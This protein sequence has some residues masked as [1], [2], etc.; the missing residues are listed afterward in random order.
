MHIKRYGKSSSSLFNIKKSFLEENDL[1]VNK[2]KQFAKAYINQPKRTKCKNC[3][4]L[5]NPASDFTKDS[6]AYVICTHC[7]HLNGTHEDTD[8]FCR[9]IY[10]HDSGKDYAKDY[11]SEDIDSYNFRTASIY[12]PKAEFLYTSLLNNNINPQELKYIDFGAGSGYFV[13]AL[14]KIG[15]NNVYGTEV[16]QAQTDFG[17]LMIGENVLSTHNIENTQKVLSET[18]CQVVS[19]IG[20]LE[21]IQKPRE[22]LNQLKVN[23]NVKYLYISVPTFSLSVYLE[24]LSNEIFHRQLHGGHTHLYTE[25]SLLYLCKEFGFKIIAEWW[26]GTDIMDL[27]RH[28]SVTLKKLKSSEKLISLW[29]QEFLPIIDSIQMEIDKQHLSSEAHI[30]L[31]KI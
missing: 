1:L 27:F 16:S 9:A 4:N 26:F 8:E 22:A 6:I 17:N 7:H 31:K 20:V 19:M 12:I 30:V 23:D 2:Q 18:E 25:K 24:I 29:H 13:A 21:H 3:N 11:T 14:K 15:L 28:I 10:T 5:L